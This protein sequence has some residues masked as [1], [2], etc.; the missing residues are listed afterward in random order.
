MTANPPLRIALTPGEP[1]GIGPDLVLQIAQQA[2]SFELVAIADPDLL[3]D[4]CKLLGLSVVLSEYDREATPTPGQPGTLLVETVASAVP[5][6]PGKL[7]PRNGNY[8]LETLRR[9]VDGCLTDEFA[10]LV[11]GPV[12]KS[13][14]NES[15]SEFSGHT[16]FLAQ[17]CNIDQ[18]VML[19]CTDSMRVAL[20]TTHLALRDV[21]AGITAQ[22]IEAVGT[23]LATDLQRLFGIE[24]PRIAVLGLNP[25]AGEAGQL[26]QEEIEIITP[27]V[28]RLSERGFKVF[29]PVP[30]DSAF[31]P[32]SLTQCDA[33]LAMYHDQGLPALKHAGFGGAVNVTLGLPIIRTSVDHGTAL[34]I[35]GN[36]TARPD[37]LLLAIETACDFARRSI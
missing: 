32:E 5:P 18:P 3:A 30:A 35:A 16:E 20:V 1:A 36:G 25:H 28:Q 13:V 10:A 15:G 2:R 22:R 24:Q 6:N 9:A 34:K 33:I 19:L 37:S 29:G 12:Q 27:T 8:V 23:I 4:R 31:T 21:P 7:D 17:A 14:I 11:T 26:G